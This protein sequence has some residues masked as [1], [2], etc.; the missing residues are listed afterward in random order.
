MKVHRGLRKK[1][2]LEPR[3]KWHEHIPGGALENC[4]PRVLWDINIQ[5]ENMIE[6][7]RPDIAVID[8]RERESLRH[9]G[10]CFVC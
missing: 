1:N 9:C 6:A 7:R 10:H 4:S 3:E 5:C 2:E 8:K